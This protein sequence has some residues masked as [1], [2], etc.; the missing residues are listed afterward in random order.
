MYGVPDVKLKCM[1][2]SLFTVVSITNILK[3]LPNLTICC[4]LFSDSL[5]NNFSC[6][7]EKSLTWEK[8]SDKL[9]ELWEFRLFYWVS[10]WGKVVYWQL[11]DESKST[12]SQ[13]YH[14]QSKDKTIRRTWVHV[15]T[16]CSSKTRLWPSP[17]K[18]NLW[19]CH[20]MSCLSDL[21]APW[22]SCSSGVSLFVMWESVY[23]LHY[24]D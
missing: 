1:T 12:N 8:P 5:F 6:Y 16:L 3:I 22:S 2:S 10:D 15:D 11:V 19:L 13:A 20:V 7:G 14:L 9:W 4:L 18:C 17:A 24:C 21:I 23:F